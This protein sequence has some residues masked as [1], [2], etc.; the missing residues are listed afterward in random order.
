MGKLIL[1]SILIATIAFP[2]MA[3]RDRSPIRGLRRAVLAMAAFNVVY[4]FAAVY[5]FPRLP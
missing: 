4:L 1:V 5:L 2:M 3:A